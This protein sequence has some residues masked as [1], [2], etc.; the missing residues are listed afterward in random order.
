V[1]GIIADINIQGHVD[2]LVAKVQTVHWQIFWDD[3]HLRYAHFSEVGLMPNDPDSL[4]WD[5]CQKE[6]LVLITDN[7]NEEDPDSLESAIRS[8]NT[9]VSLPVFTIASIPHLRQSRDYADRVIERMLD[10]LMR[11]ESLRGTGRLFLP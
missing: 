9:S 3:L 5:T 1:K 7:R 8:R 2:L 6:E 11:I 4:I 10:F